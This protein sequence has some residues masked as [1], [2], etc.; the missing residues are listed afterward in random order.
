MSQN[1]FKVLHVLDFLHTIHPAQFSY[2][3]MTVARQE[4]NQN[5]EFICYIQSSTYFHMVDSLNNNHT[6]LLVLH[7]SK[8]WFA[9]LCCQYYRRYL[10]FRSDLNFIKNQNRRYL[11]KILYVSLFKKGRPHFEN[12][13]TRGIL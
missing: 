2:R 6:I 12:A 7:I 1:K 13:K 5:F 4:L 8:M 9:L 3:N 11:N 10:K